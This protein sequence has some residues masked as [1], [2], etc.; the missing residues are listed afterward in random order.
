MNNLK[1]AAINPYIQTNIISPEEKEI[2]SQDF[3]EFG[4]RNEI[5]RASCRERV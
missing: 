1:F 5:G 3:V 2:R 4:D